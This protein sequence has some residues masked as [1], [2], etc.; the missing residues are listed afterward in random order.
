MTE[1]DATGGHFTVGLA[2]ETLSRTDLGEFGRGPSDC[3]SFAAV[4]T[5]V[6]AEGSLKVGSKVNLERAMAGHGR[7][8]GHFVQV[9]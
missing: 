2:N 7:F 5:M 4:L 3:L 9:S 1:F 6:C 8:G